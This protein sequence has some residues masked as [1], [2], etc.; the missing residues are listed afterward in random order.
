MTLD[1]NIVASIFADDQ[2]VQLA[3][4]FGSSRDG[5]IRPGHDV[6]IGI[7]LSPKPT[8]MEFYSFYQKI[9]TDLNMIPELDLVDLSN[10][11]SI[12]AFEALCGERIFVRDQEIVATFSSETARQYEDDMLHAKRY[13]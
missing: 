10:A 5:I 7:L 2:R 13:L 11:N 12:L 4:L 3:V 9:A 6:D 8:P 1:L